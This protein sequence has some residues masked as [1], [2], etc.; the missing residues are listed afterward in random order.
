MSKLLYEI[1]QQNDEKNH[2]E[3]M[4]KQLFWSDHYLEIACSGLISK[5]KYLFRLSSA[6]V[7]VMIQEDYFNLNS[8]WKLLVSSAQIYVDRVL[9]SIQHIVNFPVTKDNQKRD[10]Y[11][12]Y[13][14]IIPFFAHLNLYLAV[15]Y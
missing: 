13:K 7:S 9:F 11:L 6:L 3:A 14:V 5:R 12:I 2:V 15:F 1:I 10:A 8:L 4:K